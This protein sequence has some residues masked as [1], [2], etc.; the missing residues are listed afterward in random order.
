MTSI[1]PNASSS[2][3]KSNSSSSHPPPY[4]PHQGQ[5][6]P[7]SFDS[8]S[9]RSGSQTG[10]SLAAP[11]NNQHQRKSHKNTRKPSLREDEDMMAESVSV[12]S[13][14]S[15]THLLIQQSALRNPNSRRGQTSITHLMNFNLPPRPQDY[16]NNSYRGPARRSNLYGI[17][18]GHHSSDKA[19]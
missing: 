4:Q 15:R 7:S 1:P 6:S 8:G 9:R 19:R 13:D 18:S 16:R 11:R 3:G 14:A 2:A 10:Q 17:G 12:P 5:S